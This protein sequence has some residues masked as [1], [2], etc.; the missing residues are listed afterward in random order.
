MVAVPEAAWAQQAP[1][2][3]QQPAKKTKRPRAQPPPPQL[4][5][6]DQLAPRQLEQRVPARSKRPTEPPEQDQPA[7]AQPAPP[8]QPARAIACSGVF[9]KESSHLK[10]AQAFDSRN[11]TFTE[12]DG[13][14]GSKLMASVL[15]PRDP[16][17]RLEVLWHN[18]GSR[19]Q[20]NLIV[21]SG[22]STWTAPKGLRLGLPLVA[23]EKLNGKPFKLNGFDNE[24]AGQ[25][26]DWQDGAL[27][28]LPGGCQVGI[29]LAPDPKAPEAARGEVSGNQA[30]VSS[31]AKMRAVAPKVSEIILGY[32]Q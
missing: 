2:E 22:Q 19:S 18:E 16:K 23:L 21:I 31:D 12:V 26:T 10:L 9:G 15:F 25:V 8:R 4:E 24:S 17:R 13:P 7:D 11:L 30:F 32:S 6:E 1:D 14:E 27:A 3:S 5:E 20:T 29:R 28:K